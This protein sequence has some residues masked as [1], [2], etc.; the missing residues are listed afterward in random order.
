MYLLRSRLFKTGRLL[1]ALLSLSTICSAEPLTL[2]QAE[3]LALEQNQALHAADSNAIS[4]AAMPEQA[5]SLH[6]PTLSLNAL[7]LPVDSFSTSQEAMTQMQLGISQRLPFPGKLG[8][9]QQ[10]A[11]ELAGAAA[12]NRDELRLLLL[13]NV[14]IY[15]WNLAY[16]DKALQ[17]VK[18]N[19][20]LLRNL[21]QRASSPIVMLE[22]TQLPW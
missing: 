8:L 9:K 12:S 19:Q 11:A 18:N 21:S 22:K 4:M 15:W 3:K 5:G 7:N 10:A 1:S 20:V 6:D 2:R 16:L 13:R 17:I 14:R